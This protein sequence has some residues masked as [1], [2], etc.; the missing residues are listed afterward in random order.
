M[1]RESPSEYASLAQLT[2]QL[3]VFQ[4]G[5]FE[6]HSTPPKNTRQARLGDLENAG[7]WRAGRDSNP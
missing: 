5:G 4:V 1:T 6:G 2:G 3:D 7:N